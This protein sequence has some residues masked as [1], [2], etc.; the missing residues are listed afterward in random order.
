MK[1]GTQ[2]STEAKSGSSLRRFSCCGSGTLPDATSGENMRCWASLWTPSAHCVRD[3][4]VN[5]RAQVLTNIHISRVYGDDEFQGA[6]PATM[7]TNTAC[8]W[9]MRTHLSNSAAR[10]MLCAYLRRVTPLLLQ[11][12]S[13]VHLC[14]W[15]RGWVT[16]AQP[17]AT[18]VSNAM[19]LDLYPLRLMTWGFCPS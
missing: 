6:V 9:R 15:K 11:A 4:V 14:M 10:A 16:K 18:A 19:L 7:S 12:I 2:K 8:V 5:L 17:T 1:T 13:F 3:Q